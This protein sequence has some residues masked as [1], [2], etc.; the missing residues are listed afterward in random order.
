VIYF[1]IGAIIG[2]GLI[3]LG[4]ILHWSGY[5]AGKKELE[6]KLRSLEIQSGELCRRCGWRFEV[7]GVLGKGKGGC[8]NCDCEKIADYRRSDEFS[9]LGRK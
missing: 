3:T 1:T 5:L 4:P 7:P 6:N 2:I 8:Y 9:N